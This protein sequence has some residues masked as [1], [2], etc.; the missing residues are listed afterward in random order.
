MGNEYGKNPA[1]TGVFPIRFGNYEL[2]SSLLDLRCRVR[3]QAHGHT[4]V[5]VVGVHARRPRS[6]SKPR[7][8]EGS[9]VM[10]GEYCN[11]LC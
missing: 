7:V 10:R 6:S 3:L 4:H 8:I 1:M 5:G 9:E 2:R 11:C